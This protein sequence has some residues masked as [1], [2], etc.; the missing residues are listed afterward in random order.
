MFNITSSTSRHWISRNNNS[1]PAPIANFD[2]TISGP[3]S[4]S[5]LLAFYSTSTGSPTGWYWEIIRPSGSTY[6]TATTESLSSFIAEEGVWTITLEVSNAFGNSPV[7]VKQFLV[8]KTRFE[9]GLY[10]YDTTGS[11]SGAAYKVI[12]SFNPGNKTYRIDSGSD[13]NCGE[14][15]P[16]S[17]IVPPPTGDIGLVQANK[18][19]LQREN[20]PL[21]VSPFVP[22]SR[23]DVNTLNIYIPPD[24]GNFDAAAASLI[25][26]GYTALS[27]TVYSGAIDEVTTS[28][29]ASFNITVSGG[30]YTISSSITTL[31]TCAAGTYLK[32]TGDKL[33]GQSPLN[34]MYCMVTAIIPFPFAFSSTGNI[35]AIGY[36]TGTPAT[37][38]NVSNGDTFSSVTAR[39][40][41]SVNIKTYAGAVQGL[42]CTPPIVVRALPGNIS[43]SRETAYEVANSIGITNDIAVQY[44]NTLDQDD[45]FNGTTITYSCLGYTSWKTWGAA[46]RDY[47]TVVPGTLDSYYEITDKYFSQVEFLLTSNVLPGSTTFIDSSSKN[48][49]IT[50]IG[51]NIIS[52]SSPLRWNNSSSSINFTSPSTTRG[53]IV[54]DIPNISFNVDFT[55]E[56]W[57]YIN[58]VGKH[59]FVC[60][61][62]PRR[63]LMTRTSGVL[64]VSN[65]SGT[66]SAS[67]YT[68][69]GTTVVSPGVWHHVAWVRWA[70]DQYLFLDGNLESSTF[71]T[72]TYDPTSINIGAYTSAGTGDLLNG[73]I[74][75]IRITNR[76]PRY[77]FNFKPP[78][79][80]FATTS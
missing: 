5:D 77:V 52:G 60:L 33:G 78:S 18:L 6:G 67:G 53:L 38:F 26:G 63:Q 4:S 50:N 19:K 14:F 62:G 76:V 22:I 13:I 41:S 37:E 16:P 27:S 23:P 36:I 40:T 74:D 39:G 61:G 21:G 69:S 73:F 66:G 29:V 65:G 9:W 56:A 70:G 42:V 30:N 31:I 3:A 24:Y 8:W 80:P 44:T 51:N 46:Q 48:R 10:A 58:S 32:V 43:Y 12:N 64:A 15:P 34:D 72:T 75:S 54:S 49:D 45:I 35:T 55:I 68:M 47:L 71:S 17:T 11:Y 57:V 20:V 79:R 2:I 1:G 7:C 28:N 25:N 59:G